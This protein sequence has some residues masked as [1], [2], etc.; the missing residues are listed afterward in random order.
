MKYLIN[1]L[2]F[3]LICQSS[4]AQND[5]SKQQ[6]LDAQSARFSA[7]ME[8]DVE[9]LDK[10]LADEL[11]YTHTSGWIENKSG[12]LKTVESKK[13]DYLSMITRDVNVRIYDET[14]VVTGL[15]DVK[16]NYE[17]KPW[18]N[19][20]RFLEVYNKLDDAWLLVASQRLKN[21]TKMKN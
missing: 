10:M 19:T 9:K 11:T 18:E 15:V 13:I 14:A 4:V 20:L 2:I 7:M 1:T 21:T 5:N 12:Y 6:V 3:F 16:L 8:A 17:G